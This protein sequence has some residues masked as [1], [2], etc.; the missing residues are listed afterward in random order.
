MLQLYFILNNTI[1][2]GYKFNS[3]KKKNAEV[4]KT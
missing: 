3:L 2:K 1:K 4:I